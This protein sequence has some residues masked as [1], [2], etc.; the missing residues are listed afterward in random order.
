[1]SGQLLPVMT[2]GMVTYGER[3]RRTVTDLKYHHKKALALEIALTLVDAFQLMGE[4][5]VLT[6]VPTSEQ[7]RLQR[8]FDH[9]ELIT[10][11]VGA[12]QSVPVKRL[13]RRTSH[14]HQTGQ[15]RASRLQGVTF[16]ASPAARCRRIVIIDDVRTTGATFVAATQALGLR[17]ATSIVCLSYAFVP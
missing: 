7:H 17:D 9:A 11:H 10:R 1:M 12:L 15:S 2:I 13:L 4:V 14:G 16:V 8:G 6:W 5:D 3:A